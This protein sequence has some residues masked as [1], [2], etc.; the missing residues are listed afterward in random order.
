MDDYR[1]GKR[2][3]EWGEGK[4]QTITFVVTQDCNLQC[5]YCY[6]ISKNDKNIMTFDVAK[7]AI[8]FFLENPQGVYMPNAVI[9]DF[10]GGEPLLEI[11][12]IDKFEQYIDCKARRYI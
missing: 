3:L 7:R 9:L 5:K 4:T 6:M 1:L 8:D 2:V 12:L 11:D 10:I